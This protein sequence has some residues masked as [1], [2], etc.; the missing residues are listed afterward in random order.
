MLVDLQYII[1]LFQMDTIENIFIL[2]VLYFYY[3]R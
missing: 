3:V 1:T 2:Y